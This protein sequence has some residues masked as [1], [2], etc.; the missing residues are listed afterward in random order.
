MRRFQVVVVG[1]S[2]AT[3]A[4]CA[5]AEQ[6]GR[7]VARLGAV[8]I[9]GGR[10]GVME[11]ASRGARALGGVTVGIVPSERFD[12]ANDA[13]DIVIPT[14]MGWARNAVNVL[15]ADLVVAIGGRAGTLT[16][17]A[18]AWAYGK[19]VVAFSAADGWS[20]RLAGTS[21]DD[22]RTDCI[23]RADTVEELE[24]ELRRRISARL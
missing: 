1:D 14:G 10:G 19:P 11:A 3:T 24:A 12:E 17:I 13:C 4:A 7:S 2:D 20:E 16:E 22:R 5:L 18:Y 8:L 9:S 15:S 23:L 6:V 21:L